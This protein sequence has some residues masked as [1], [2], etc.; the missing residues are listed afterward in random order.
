M[1]ENTRLTIGEQKNA[2]QNFYNPLLTE[3]RDKLE[4]FSICKML[5]NKKSRTYGTSVADPG[6]SKWGG[7]AHP[8]CHKMGGVKS[9]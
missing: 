8:V 7:G 9:A 5:S 1:H 2:I 3:F 6:F 4:H